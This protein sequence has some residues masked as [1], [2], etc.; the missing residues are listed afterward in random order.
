M[1]DRNIQTI[2]KKSSMPIRI[3]KILLFT[4]IC[5]FVMSALL[6][7]YI[8]WVPEKAAY[9][10][11]E[12]RPNTLWLLEYGSAALPCVAVAAVLTVLYR[13]WYVPV[14]TQRDKTVVI[15]LVAVF[16]YGVLLPMII[17]NNGGW[18]TVRIIEVEK[19]EE[20]IVTLFGQTYVWFFT[21]LIPFVLMLAYHIT[22]ASAEKRELI[23]AEE[24]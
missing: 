2:P 22:K 15:L 16:T 19:K 10:E 24:E 4:L 8:S 12:E 17:T 18:D 6:T 20:E 14:E 11:E 5:C 3:L 23:N 13:L 7:W 1:D 9:L 21:Q